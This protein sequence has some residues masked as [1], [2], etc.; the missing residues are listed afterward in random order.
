MENWVYRKENNLPEIMRAGKEK[1]LYLNEKVNIGLWL[2]STD[3]K[4]LLRR[5]NVKSMSYLMLYPQGESC[6]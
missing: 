5:Q 4:P 1:D 3:V 2:K 6:L